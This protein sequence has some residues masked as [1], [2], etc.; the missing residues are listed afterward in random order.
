MQTFVLTLFIPASDDEQVMFSG[1]PMDTV[2]AVRRYDVD[3]VRPMKSLKHQLS[4]M[5]TPM[6]LF[7]IPE[8]VLKL[9]DSSK[10]PLIDEASLADLDNFASE[11]GTQLRSAIN[12][13]RVTKDEH[14]IALIELANQISAKAH[15][16]VRL[17]VG[18][19]EN[20]RQLQAI[21]L[22]RCMAEGCVEQAYQ[23]TFASGTAA[24]TLRYVANDQPLA[25]KLNVLVDAG[26]EYRCY[27]SGI[28]RTFPISGK[29]SRESRAIYEIVLKMQ[30]RCIDMCKAGLEWEVAHET[31]HRVAI[32]GLLDLGIL[33]DG[34]VKTI[35]DAGTSYG[36]F[37]HGIGH[38]LGLD[39]HVRYTVPF[40]IPILFLFCEISVFHSIFPIYIP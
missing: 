27:A 1:P 2:E 40:T 29:F 12:E 18:Q 25:G 26:G 23:G 10:F 7:Y 36:F 15:E 30:A 17:S 4:T 39:T 21:F 20:E 32:E 34:D 28:T 37:P 14:E 3:D 33:K 31:A 13:C 8:H 35:L 9:E 24:A 16:A 6:H 11:D 19:C 38:F 5:S 22:Q